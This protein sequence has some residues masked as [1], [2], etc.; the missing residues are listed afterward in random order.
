MVPLHF[1][2][3]DTYALAPHHTSALMA[4]VMKKT[5]I[6]G[7]LR[8]SIDLLGSPE[9]WWGF[10]I[11][12]FGAAS[13]IFGAFYALPESNIK[14]LLAY[15]SVENVGI[16]LM[17][18]GLGV[19]GLGLDLP[20]LA[21]LGL[22]AALYHILNHSFFKSLLYLSSG[23]A[24]D[25]TNTMNL[26]Q[27]GGLRRYLP[28]TAL[29]F[30]IGAI[31]VTAI[32]PLNGFVSEW[33]TYQAF[34]LASQSSLLI[35]R[36]LSPLFA[37]LMAFAG[38]LAFMVYIKAYASIFS[39]PT[40]IKKPGTYHEPP[41]LTMIGLSLLALGCVFLGIASPWISPLIAQI[42]A[43]SLNSP[44]INVSQGQVIFPA[45]ASQAVLSTPIVAIFLVGLLAIP[46]MIILV[47]GGY[48]PGKRTN[49][50]PWSCGY[51]YS[52]RMSVTAASFYQ[53]VK[54]NF[55]P[56]Y[57]LR[58]VTDLP[59]QT[60]RGFSV[61]LKTQIIRAEP[62]IETIIT[63][64][65]TRLVETAGLWIQAMQMGDIRVYCLYIIVTLAILLIAIFGRSGL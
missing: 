42:A 34:F 37:V 20:V 46:V 38:A 18:A 31:A 45:S 63:K 24:I 28:G 47:L 54:V 30:F 12:I 50:E 35:I 17:G 25:Q 58:S 44:A 1:W 41:V 11:L 39:G 8:I 4:G 48:R 27:M 65:I 64:P 23:W 56:I 53:P 14:R 16:I 22:M 33:F 60:I 7:I 3:P 51:G 61:N 29:L 10:I 19:V 9:W 55:H 36:V 32:P 5:A 2:T 13:T 43:R 62:Y 26:N 49:V 40:Q 21:T 52:P 6:Y 57:W 59:F 15:S